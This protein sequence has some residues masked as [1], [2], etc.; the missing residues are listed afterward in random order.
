MVSVPCWRR[1]GRPDAR[2]GLPKSISSEPE[3]RQWRGPR[4]ALALLDT[5]RVPA[6]EE[7][8]RA[9]K[10]TAVRKSVLGTAQDAFRPAPDGL[11]S[12]ERHTRRRVRLCGLGRAPRLRAPRPAEKVAAAH[13]QRPQRDGHVDAPVRR[14][15]VPSVRSTTS[16]AH[17]GTFGGSA[18]KLFPSIVLRREPHRA[19][20]S[21]RVRGFRRARTGSGTVG[22]AAA[23]GGPVRG[24][25]DLGRAQHLSSSGGGDTQV[26]PG[27]TF[28]GKDAAFGTG[29]KD[30][31]RLRAVR[32][33]N[34][35][36]KVA[37]PW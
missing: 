6:A 32:K 29:T 35:D 27:P 4:Q 34:R 7:Y 5:F 8:A 23:N 21:V 24:F 28:S 37:H 16:C 2:T 12:I 9:A 31:R 26:R 3:R 11:G 19:P 13:G 17:G 10:D 15:R 18:D 25:Q 22:Q 33:S 30:H 1:R 36:L 20:G 14:T